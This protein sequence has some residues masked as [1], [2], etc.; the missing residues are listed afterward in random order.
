[1][2]PVEC[3]SAGVVD[4]ALACVRRFSGVERVVQP[5]VAA[6]CNLCLDGDVQ[7]EVVGK[8]G[9]DVVVAAL[10]AFPGSAD[11]TVGL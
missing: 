1:M 2:E 9:V 5:A 4:D 8:G 11:V 10:R 6:L 7:L 3:A